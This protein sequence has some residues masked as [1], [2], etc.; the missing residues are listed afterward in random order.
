M[1]TERKSSL[2]MLGLLSLLIFVY[3]TGAGIQLVYG[4]E[5]SATSQFLYHAA[6]IC[7]VVWWL[8]AEGRS[9][10]QPVYCEGLLVGAGWFI[11][12]PYHLLKTRGAKGLIPLVVLITSFVIAQILTIILYV[13]LLASNPP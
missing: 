6:F 2:I 1:T 10:V 8:K 4:S 7:G 5:P 11:I 9:A 13:A 3:N 12:I